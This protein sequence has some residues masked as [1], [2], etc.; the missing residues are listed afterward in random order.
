MEKNLA[1]FGLIPFRN[2]SYSVYHDTLA[3]LYQHEPYENR[4]ILF[5]LES[6]AF[7]FFDE[8]FNTIDEVDD[9]PY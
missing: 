2:L 9:L 5:N 6:Y 1:F 4:P 8:H 7:S 3:R